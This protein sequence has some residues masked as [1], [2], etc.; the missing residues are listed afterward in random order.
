M[1]AEINTLEELDTYD[2]VPREEVGEATI[3]DSTWAF[4][5]KRYPDGRTGKHKARI[6]V[7]GDQQEN[8]YDYFDTYAPVVSWNT[9]RLL[10]ILT[11]T[12]GL[13]TKQVDYTLAFCQAKLDPREPPIY[14]EMPRMFEK[15]GHVLSLKRSIY[16]MR[17]SPLNFFLNLK[18]GLE[19]RGFRQ[20]ELDPCLF[21]NG[22]V[23]CLCYVDD[24]LWYA[25]SEK[26]IDDVIE[27]LKHPGD[28]SMIQFILN[29][30]DDVA[31]FLG[32]HFNKVKGIDG[33]I[34]EIELTQVGLIRLFFKAKC[35]EDCT[36]IATPAESKA[37]GKDLDG[38]PQME[39]WS[40]A[41]VVGMLMYLA[42][43]SRPDIAFAVH[44]CA[45]YT[46]GTR[47]SHEK[48]VKRIIRYL[49]G[50]ETKGLIIKPTSNLQIDLYADADFSGL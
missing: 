32:I 22:M 47:R 31:G 13:H 48:A 30:E 25:K 37:L 4:K 40:Y 3:L 44:Q 16:G 7:R 29:E 15:P 41:S 35:M 39:C 11:A 28:K 21:S 24:C 33:K 49:R 10:L 45:R 50:T 27:N 34:C 42:S 36:V 6:C 9:V 17:Q 23:I 18:E 19:Q 12:L 8:G 38:D 2:I 1:E 20:S 5:T 46:H 43:N 14:V 26:D